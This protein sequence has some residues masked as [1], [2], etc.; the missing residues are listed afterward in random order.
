MRE[1]DLLEFADL[2]T[3]WFAELTNRWV[4]EGCSPDLRVSFSLREAAEI[5]G[6][7]GGGG[8]Q[9]QLVTAAAQR[10]IRAPAPG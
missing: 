2:A 3:C 8:R 7:K 1:G 4:R 10:Q 6:Y 5:L 9:L